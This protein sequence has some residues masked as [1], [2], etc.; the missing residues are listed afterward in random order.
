MRYLC[1]VVICLLSSKST[2][3]G[4]SEFLHYACRR[5]LYYMYALHVGCPAV[6]LILIVW[7]RVAALEKVDVLAA[8]LPH[9]YNTHRVFCCRA[10]V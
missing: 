4:G 7:V 8:T 2:S 5:L 1:A 3:A 6:R 9:A 10:E